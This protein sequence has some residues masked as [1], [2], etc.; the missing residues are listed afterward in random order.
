VDGWISAGSLGLA[1][2]DLE[3][4]ASAIES[5]GAGS[6]PIHPVGPAD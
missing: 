1:T 6:G 4:I 5:T 3:E 2:E